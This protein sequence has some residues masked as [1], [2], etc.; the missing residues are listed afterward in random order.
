ME[1]QGMSG[2]IGREGKGLEGER[3]SKEQRVT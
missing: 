1:G 3:E 2:V